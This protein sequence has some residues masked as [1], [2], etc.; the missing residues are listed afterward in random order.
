GFMLYAANMAAFPMIS[1]VIRQGQQSVMALKY[2][3]FP[4]VSAL[5]GMALGGGCETVL[6]S[7]HVQAHLESYAG[8]VEVGVG[9][10]P[11]WGGCKEMVSRH[12]PADGKGGA[13]PG[14]SKAFEVIATAKV[15]ESAELCRDM[16]IL[17]DSD[18][19]TMNRERLLADAK[20]TCLKAAEHFEQKEQH[21]IH[22]PGK[23][24]WAAL[25]MAVDNF[26]ASG[27]A[28]THD[29]YIARHL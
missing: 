18:G 29:A 7:T 19:I 22:L 10:I 12:V 6:H 17:R 4:V 27:I 14:I 26:V 8:L 21:T 28:S 15:G 11:G 2:A 23:G 25:N 16:G 5:H 1:D 20:A 13:M 24:G 9:L 3:P